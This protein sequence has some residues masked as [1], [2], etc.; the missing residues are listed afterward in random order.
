LAING[1]DFRCRRGREL[2]SQGHE[3]RGKLWGAS[4]GKSGGAQQTALLKKRARRNG[5][6]GGQGGGLRTKQQEGREI[7]KKG[8]AQG[9]MQIEKKKKGTGKWGETNQGGGR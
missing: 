7:D 4:K 3:K 9:K 1:Q 2:R 8:K 5:K 6:K